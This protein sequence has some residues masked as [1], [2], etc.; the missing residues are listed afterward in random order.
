MLLKKVVRGKYLNQVAVRV[1]LLIKF[2]ISINWLICCL[3]LEDD[4][5]KKKKKF[6]DLSKSTRHFSQKE[7]QF[8]VSLAGVRVQ[9]SRVRVQLWHVRIVL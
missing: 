6:T 3:F 7:N 8:R 4:F 5:C 2:M 1:R 9:L